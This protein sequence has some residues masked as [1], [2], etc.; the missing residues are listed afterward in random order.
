MAKKQS[1]GVSI[2]GM[3]VNVGGDV[4]GRDKITTT[5]Y[6]ASDGFKKIR[7]LIEKRPEDPNVDKDELKDT[8]D[9]IESEVKKGEEANPAKV[10]RWLKFLASMADDIFQ[11]TAATLVNPGA[12]VAKAIQLI[13]KKAKE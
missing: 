12:G 9:K 10:E 11:V 1:G 4:V 13:V 2:K 8:V 7:E 5:H 6:G 3:K